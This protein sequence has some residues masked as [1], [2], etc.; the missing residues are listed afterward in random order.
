M[1]RIPFALDFENHDGFT[2]EM[3]KIKDAEVAVKVCNR[4]S[5]EN[6]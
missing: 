6:V 5:F 2:Y 4:G 1:L 3:G